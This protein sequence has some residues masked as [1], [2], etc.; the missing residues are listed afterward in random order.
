MG[1]HDALRP[2]A[3]P[4]DVV[5]KQLQHCVDVVADEAAFDKGA[6]TFLDPF[7]LV[8]KRIRL[9]FLWSHS[10]HILSRRAPLRGLCFVIRLHLL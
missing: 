3:D 9:M 8:F 7:A 5:A 1:A 4:D 10:S 6:E 2:H